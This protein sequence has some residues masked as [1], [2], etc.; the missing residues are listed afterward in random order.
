LVNDN[1]VAVYATPVE[2]S[3]KAYLVENPLPIEFEV[4]E[5][6]V[7]K[8][9]PEVIDAIGQTAQDFVYSPLALM[10]LKLSTFWW[11]LLCIMKRW[12]ILS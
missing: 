7:T 6:V 4:S 9:S 3:E 5:D 1:N 11:L 10:W 12:I 2:G 8:V